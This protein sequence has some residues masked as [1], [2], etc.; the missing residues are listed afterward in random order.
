MFHPTQPDLSQHKVIARFWRFCGII[1]HRSP[2]LDG[3]L[4]VE[5]MEFD[6]TQEDEV[7][8]N[9]DGFIVE[10]EGVE[11]DSSIEEAMV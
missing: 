3:C 6:F 10:E 11:G 1:T 4:E 8:G 9:F 5:G 2:I 7:F